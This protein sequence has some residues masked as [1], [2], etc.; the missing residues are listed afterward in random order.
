[1]H[2]W[3]WLETMDEGPKERFLQKEGKCENIEAV[4]RVGRVVGERMVRGK[5]GG[6]ADR[7]T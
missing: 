4:A 3:Q 2:D 5:V 1:M 6:C 7:A